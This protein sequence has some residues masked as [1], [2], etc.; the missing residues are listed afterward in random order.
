MPKDI[1]IL[2]RVV[3]EL[4]AQ[5]SRWGDQSHKGDGVWALILSE[6]AGEACKAI[7]H[8]W[9]K[10]TPPHDAIEELIQVAAVAIQWATAISQRGIQENTSTKWGEPCPLLQSH[11]GAKCNENRRRRGL[12]PI[13]H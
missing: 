7:L 5:D 6:E 9:E 10:G 1:G 2:W 11:N 8:H 12:A 13:P 3:A 4:D